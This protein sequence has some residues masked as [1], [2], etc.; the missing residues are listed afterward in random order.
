M[1]RR[2]TS[3]YFSGSSLDRVDHHRQNADWIANAVADDGSYFVLVVEGDVMV[4][5]NGQR[6]LARREEVSHLLTGDHTLTTLLAH[7]MT[8]RCS[9]SPHRKMR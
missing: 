2:V 6:V 3:N 8:R 1:R 4:H 9:L 5:P 7:G